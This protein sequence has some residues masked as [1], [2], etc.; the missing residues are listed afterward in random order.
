MLEPRSATGEPGGQQRR[1]GGDV[2]DR[3]RRRAPRRVVAV[4][5]HVVADAP[6]SPAAVRPRAPCRRGSPCAT[7]R[8]AGSRARPTGRRPAGRARGRGRRPEC[9]MLPPDHGRRDP[10]RLPRGLRPCTTAGCRSAAATRSSWRASSARPAYVMAEDDLRARAREFRTALAAHHDGPGEVIFASKACPGTAVLR[11]FA[12]EG[13][14]VRR[15][16]GRRAAPRA[17]RPGSSPRGSTSTATRSREEELRAGGRGRRRQDRRRQ[18]TTTSPSSRAC[19][20]A[21]AR[22]R[23]AAARSAR[24]STPTRTRRSSPGHAESKFGLDPR[25]ARALAHD[26]PGAPR[27]PRAS[28]STSAP[29]S[30]TRRPTARPSAC[31]R[32]LGRPARLLPRRRLRGRL[33]RRRPAAG[34]RRVGR[35]GRRGGPRPARARTSA[36]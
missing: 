1:G 9:V 20:R 28:T 13:L 30:T 4:P 29:S 7:R 35:R 22:Q 3:P 23:G 18:R 6:T 21:G 25:E 33:H 17:A 36:S 34:D 27:R 14:G 12:E 10:F 31:W 24:A 19:C 8:R 5:A 32:G 11:V 16:L 15:R 2:R 26:P